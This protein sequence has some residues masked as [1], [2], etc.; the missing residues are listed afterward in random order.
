MILIIGMII[1]C[2]LYRLADCYT[3]AVKW[4]SKLYNFIVYETLILLIMESSLE[5]S[6]SCLID[7]ARF[8]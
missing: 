3:W 8:V 4:K 5:I 6:I 2:C 7:I 1:Y